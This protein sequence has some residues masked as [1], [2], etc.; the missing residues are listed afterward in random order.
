MEMHVMVSRPCCPKIYI[1]LTSHTVQYLASVAAY[2]CRVEEDV[3]HVEAH[4]PDNN[5]GGS[6]DASEV[7]DLTP[8]KRAKTYY[9][10]DMKAAGEICGVRVRVHH[11]GK[12]KSKQIAC[13]SATYEEARGRAE[14]HANIVL[15]GG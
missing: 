6:D 5:E 14:Q 9:I 8:S 7:D 13:T 4:D 10:S 12:I 2:Q 3:A 11:G 15:S 1:E